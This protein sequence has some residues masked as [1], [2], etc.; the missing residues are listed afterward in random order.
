MEAYMDLIINGDGGRQLRKCK[1]VKKKFGSLN[2][3][4]DHS[5]GFKLLK[6]NNKL[7]Y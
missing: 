2:C 4:C 5:Y 7:Q 3:N 6:I 1:L